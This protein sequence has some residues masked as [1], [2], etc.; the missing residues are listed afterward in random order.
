MVW[1]LRKIFWNESYFL[2]FIFTYIYKKQN[3]IVLVKKKE[4]NLKASFEGYKKHTLHYKL[5]MQWSLYFK[6]THGTMNIWSSTA[7]GF[8]I[9]VQ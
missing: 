6:T 4:T 8:K 1:E 7:G 2:R 5:L 9:K 3:V